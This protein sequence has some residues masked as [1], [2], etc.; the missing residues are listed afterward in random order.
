[1]SCSK[2]SYPGCPQQL[3]A[4]LPPLPCQ[5]ALPRSCQEVV[6]PVLHPREAPRDWAPAA[7]PMREE[8]TPPSAAAAARS[9]AWLTAAQPAGLDTSPDDCCSIS[10]SDTP[11]PEQAQQGSAVASCGDCHRVAVC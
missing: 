10:T 7:G 2:G 9:D 8:V 5:Q 1:M 3:L 4:G 6:H 11:P